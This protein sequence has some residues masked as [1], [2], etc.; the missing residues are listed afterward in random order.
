M[1]GTLPAGRPARGTAGEPAEA[2][3]TAMSALAAPVTL[4]TCYDD[5]GVPRGLTASAVAFLSLD[6]PL[7]LV[8]LDRRSRTHDALTGAAAFTVHLLAPGD[9]HL[10][11]SFT[12]PAEER[13]EGMALVPD[14]HPAPVLRDAALTLRC[15]RHDL[16]EG[17]NHTILVGRVTGV[18]GEPARAGGL[19]WHRRGFAHARRP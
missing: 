16:L 10:V 14:P 6:P 17:G 2:F 15:L 4:V 12:R 5:Q 18:D 8:C 11:G 1:T 19:L 13:F 9:E 3:R 7:F